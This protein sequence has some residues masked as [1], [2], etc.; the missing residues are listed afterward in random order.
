MS[1]KFHFPDALPDDHRDKFLR[2]LDRLV[3]VYRALADGPLSAADIAPA[4]TDMVRGLAY[5]FG[6]TYEDAHRAFWARV[7]DERNT[8]WRRERVR[9]AAREYL[10]RN[11]SVRWVLEVGTRDP[12]A[13]WYPNE[14]ERCPLCDSVRQPT[15][16][17]PN[18]LITHCRGP[19][20]ISRKYDITRAELLEAAQTLEE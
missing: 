16:Q 3:V 17:W 11:R 18:T 6:L 12:L 14:L 10:Q 20:H 9:E 13:R 7:E 5:R 1:D 8:R 4:L 2:H 19:E 15:R